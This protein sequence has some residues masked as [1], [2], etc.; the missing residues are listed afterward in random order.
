MPKPSVKEVP[1]QRTR[2]LRRLRKGAK[3]STNKQTKNIRKERN[4]TATRHTTY[5]LLVLVEIKRAESSRIAKYALQTHTHTTIKTDSTNNNA[6]P[7][8]PNKRLLF[9][10]LPYFCGTTKKYRQ[11]SFILLHFIRQI[12]REQQTC[13]QKSSKQSEKPVRMR[14]RKRENVK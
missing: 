11:K 4:K 13:K 2:M 12:E 14:E 1:K 8:Y 6:N 7:K 9:C 5:I 3:I 10:I